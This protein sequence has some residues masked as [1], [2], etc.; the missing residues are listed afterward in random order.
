[1]T[2]VITIVGKNY[3]PVGTPDRTEPIITKIVFIAAIK[4]TTSVI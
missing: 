4:Y 3:S 2:V 1:M